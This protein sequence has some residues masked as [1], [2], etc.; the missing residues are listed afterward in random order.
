[1]SKPLV[2][3][4]PHNLGKGEAVRR[5][6]GGLSGLKSQF[7]DKVASI[8]ETWAGDRMDFRVGAM[9]Q[10]ISGHLDVMEDQ[11]RVEVQLPWILAV[12]A[13]KAK[14]F[15]QKQGTLLLEKK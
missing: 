12:V 11:V 6:Q 2:V 13:E 14:S 7:G 3:S 9:G 10:N 5:L 1:M 8:N 15:I 4:I